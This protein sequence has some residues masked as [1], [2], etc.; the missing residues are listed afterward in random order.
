M[1]MADKSHLQIYGDLERL[2]NSVISLLDSKEINKKKVRPLLEYLRQDIKAHLRD[3]QEGSTMTQEPDGLESA[4]G[5]QGA[6]H[7]NRIR[8]LDKRLSKLESWKESL[9]D[10]GK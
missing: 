3:L 10:D 2:L 8:D 9:M 4:V 1:K 7:W 5:S 6:L